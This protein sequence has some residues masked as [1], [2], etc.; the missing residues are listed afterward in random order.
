MVDPNRPPQPKN[1]IFDPVGCGKYIAYSCR[2]CCLQCK[3]PC[4]CICCILLIVVFFI[5]YFYLNQV[6]LAPQL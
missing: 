3:W 4:L 2:E 5:A 6:G 1:P